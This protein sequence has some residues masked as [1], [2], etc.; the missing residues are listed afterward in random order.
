MSTMLS[1]RIKLRLEAWQQDPLNSE[2]SYLVFKFANQYFIFY[3]YGY[4]FLCTRGMQ[5]PWRLE[6]TLDGLGLS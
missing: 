4:V 3:E 6:E 2:H 5:C 1:I